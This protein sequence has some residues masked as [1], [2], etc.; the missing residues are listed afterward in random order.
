MGSY[1]FADGLFPLG[2]KRGETTA[3]TFFGGNLKAPV[4][5]NI[6]LRG[7]E[8][9]RR[10]TTASAPNTPVVPFVFAVSDYPELIEPSAPVSV[11][12][13][14]NGRLSE[15]GKID[16]YKIQVQ[17]G[18]R[19]LIEVQ[20]R[21]LGTSRLEA[22]LTAYDSSGK[23]ID[24]AGDKPLPED[25]FAVQG[26][27]RTSSD[28]FLDITA[29]QGAH[30]IA[31]SIEDLAARGGPQYGYRIVVRKQPDEFEL[32]VV[33]P[34][35]NIPAGGTA[36]VVVDADRRGYNGP[37]ELSVADLPKGIRFEGGM[38]PREYVDANNA[39]TFNRRGMLILSADPGVTMPT[40]DLQVWG[41]GKLDDGT[42]V[43]RRARGS[44]MSVEVTGATA[45]GVV[46]RQRPVTAP[47]MGLDLPAASTLAS[48]A[49]LEVT[50]VKL[51]RLTE[52]DRYDFAYK[53]EPR[54]QS[55]RFPNLLNVDVV[56]AR[57]IRV[58]SFEKSGMGGS[59]SISTTKA[60]D[61]ARYDIIIRG[62]VTADGVN[63]DVY[64]RPLPLIVTERSPNVQV[65]SH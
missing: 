9:Q 46:D 48:P 60:T 52:G 37:I 64:A 41:A 34:Y 22:I 54:S 20:A 57:D 65:A 3:V 1:S 24:S 55:A 39:R 26:T 35:V 27:S 30:E 7:I 17:P 5:S 63:E 19:L 21:E 4:K 43:R 16:R 2:G 12:S 18:D 10:F 51:T 6:D 8:A 44:G 29:P 56:G 23:K 38:I 32:S 45:Q 11:P 50:Q 42:M 62:R 36:I 40:R 53:W 15:A 28:P 59:F 31:L 14:I 13:V 47:W 49:K 61:P 33:S 58:T 25:V